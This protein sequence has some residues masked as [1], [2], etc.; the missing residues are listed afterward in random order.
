MVEDDDEEFDDPMDM[1][2]DYPEQDEN[3]SDEMD[4]DDLYDM[5]E[6]QFDLD[7][8]ESENEAA[9]EDTAGDSV[10]EHSDVPDVGEGQHS[11]DFM[12]MDAEEKA[13]ENG[14]QIMDNDTFDKLKITN[15]SEQDIE[16]TFENSDNDLIDHN[17]L[18]SLV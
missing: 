12:D 3:T 6:L 1:Y 9:D 17:Q 16:E 11:A 7:G 8:A 13:E 18:S 14:D 4:E 5:Y 15:W 10:S 2:A